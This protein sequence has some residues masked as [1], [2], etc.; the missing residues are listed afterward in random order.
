MRSDALIKAQKKYYDIKKND[1]EYIDKRNENM[2]LYYNNKKQDPE[3]RD[4]INKRSLEY[5][6]NNMG[7][8]DDPDYRLFHHKRL[9]HLLVLTLDLMMH[10]HL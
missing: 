5:Y 4:K 7:N 3:F 9:Y 2:R 10:L 6:Y 8:L 1:E